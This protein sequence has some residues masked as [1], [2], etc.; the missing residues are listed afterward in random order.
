MYYKKYLKYKQKYLELNRQFGG[1]HPM[2]NMNNKNN[3]ISEY[4][5][6][7][8]KGEQLG[9]NQYTF[10]QMKQNPKLIQLFKQ[11]HNAKESLE[12]LNNCDK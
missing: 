12:I 2:C 1:D 5:N 4:T 11:Y 3:M 10:H 6:I 8:Q 7:V 9:I